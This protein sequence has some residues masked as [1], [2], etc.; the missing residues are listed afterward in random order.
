[1]GN[2]T[3]VLS[4]SCNHCG[5]PLSVSPETRFVTCAHCGS[6]LEVHRSDGA[7]Y[8]QVLETVGRIADDVQA[9]RRETELER[10][11]R[12]WQMRREGLMQRGKD[13]SVSRPSMAGSAIGG[14]VAVVFGVFWTGLTIS[15][16]APGFFPLFGILFIGA[17]LFGAISGMT[18]SS[19]YDEAESEYQRRRAALLN[20]DDRT[21]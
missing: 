4:V 9:I 11:D 12:E 8:T 19:E 2:G 18:K 1:M 16:G 15:A 20:R 5:A 10:V 14:I 3:E 7:V 6:R 17:G 13:G 21:T